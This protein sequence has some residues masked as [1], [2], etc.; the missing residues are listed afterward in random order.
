MLINGVVRASKIVA[1]FFL[2]PY[3]IVGEPLKNGIMSI[4]LQLYRAWR[5]IKRFFATK[6]MQVRIERTT[7]VRIPLFLMAMTLVVTAYNIQ[8]ALAYNEREN[9][10]ILE[11]LFAHDEYTVVEARDVAELQPIPDQA[12]S[13]ISPLNS[14]IGG[15]E[16]TTEE[17]EDT[18][19]T[20]ADARGAL[21]KIDVATD[22]PLDRSTVITHI[23]EPGDTI[24]T[25]AEEYGITTDTVLWANHLSSY[26]LIQVGEKLRIPPKSGVLHKVKSGETLLGIANTYDVPADTIARENN[27]V[28]A[29]QLRVGQELVIPNGK[30]PVAP[31]RVTNQLASIDKIF[32][33]KTPT[34]T[35]KSTGGWVW[36]ITTCKRMTQYFGLRHKAIDVA[37]PKGHPIVASKA[38]RIEYAGWS[39]GYGYNVVVN[40]G[41]G[42]KTRSAHMSYI[43]VEVGDQ[44]EQGELIGDVGSTGR[45]TG[46]HI[47]FEIMIN[48]KKMNPLTYF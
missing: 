23:V 2:L 29:H 41:G 47:H 6:T 28:S 44:V 1:W 13:A 3:R 19:I 45:S 10:S 5:V 32:T 4:L 9:Q 48:N 40:H 33:S 7:L 14:A 16:P 17:D 21:M 30:P 18:V 11:R 31:R 38:G 15:P 35:T 12:L 27:L 20:I 36:P 34:E 22:Q 42:I 26:S 37:C 8:H 46:P 43:R 39:N 24:S 25:L